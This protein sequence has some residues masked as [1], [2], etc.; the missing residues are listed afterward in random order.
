MSEGWFALHRGWRDNLI[1]RGEYSRADAWVWLIENAA[2]KPSRTRIKGATVELARGELSFSQRFLAEKW[3]WSKSRVDR[4]IAELRDEGMIETRS[5]IGATADHAAGQGQCI[6]SICNYSK[7]QDV[8]DRER[9]NDASEDGATAGQQRGKEEQGN[10]ETKDEVA[11]ATPSKRAKRDVFPAL[12]DWMPVGPWDAYLKMRRLKGAWP[13]AEAVVLMIDKLAHWRAQGHD[14]G[15][16]L[17]NS[18]LNNWTGLFE[19][20]APKNE[21]DGFGIHHSRREQRTD[22]AA[23]ALDRQLGLG[24]FAPEAGRCDPGEGPGYRPLSLAAS[25]PR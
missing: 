5:K 18:T 14:P 22:G 4:F 9:G 2:W 23:R 16:I 6:I 11:K 21:T 24:E 1:F 20:K 7:Y 8:S 13:T 12:P 19:P 3:G 25:G 10:K 17:N 15:V